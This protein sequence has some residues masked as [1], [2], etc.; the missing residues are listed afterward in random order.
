VI[1]LLLACAT[2]PE[3]PWTTE[4][5]LAPHLARLDADGDGAVRAAEWQRVDDAG[6]SFEQ[7]DVDGDG[8]LAGE[9]LRALLTGLDPVKWYE[10]YGGAGPDAN[11]T[12]PRN[13]KR[14]PNAGF[15]GPGGMSPRPGGLPEMTPEERARARP[16][17]LVLRIL[18]E[19]IAAA[20][21]TLTLPDPQ[22]VE[23]AGRAGLDSPEARVL[24]G[25]L[26]DLSSRAGLAFPKGLRRA[27]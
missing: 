23:A 26:E 17:I 18:V 12:E 5:A 4:R 9:E 24:L 15:A 22:R 16:T 27:P 10:D 13:P 1:A 2:A 19:E 7:A 25:E 21:P 14:G 8:A 6:L 20:D 3:G 11:S